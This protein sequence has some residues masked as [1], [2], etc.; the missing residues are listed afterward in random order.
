MIGGFIGVGTPERLIDE[1]VEPH[2]VS[3]IRRL[4]GASR[5]KFSIMEGPCEVRRQFQTWRRNHR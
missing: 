2:S 4:P 5:N 1:L 3:R